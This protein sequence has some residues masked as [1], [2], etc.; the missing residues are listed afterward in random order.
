MGS[1][2]QPKN[3]VEVYRGSSATISLSVVDTNGA[4]VDLTGATVVMTVKERLES[5][6]NIFQ[7]SS[8]DAA[9]ILITSARGGLAEIY[10]LPADTLSRDIKQYVF[11][12]WV[13]LPSGK[14][15]VVV[16]PS[17]FD[18]QPAVTVLS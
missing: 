16:E 4:V 7:K 17:T 1:F 13:I 5:P 2:L 3:T 9:E 12:V 14:R 8:A 6:R 10:I 15:I 18:I 11:D